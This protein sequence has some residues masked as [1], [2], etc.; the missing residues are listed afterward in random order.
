MSDT[1]LAE[2]T[3]WG[4]TDQPA[5]HDIQAELAKLRADHPRLGFLRLPHR[6]VAVRGHRVLEAHTPDELRRKLAS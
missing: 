2:Q 4:L 3:M 1:T 6:W 5:G